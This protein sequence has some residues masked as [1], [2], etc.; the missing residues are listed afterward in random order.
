MKKTLS[1]LICCLFFALPLFISQPTYA[2]VIGTLESSNVILDFD[3][4]KIET[5]KVLDTTYVPVF[6]LKE[7]GCNVAFDATT[8]DVNL[9]LSATNSSPSDAASASLVGKQYELYEKNIWI[10]GFKTHGITTE[11]RVLIPIGALRQLYQININGTQYQ[12][13]VKEPLGIAAS[14][15]QITN[16]LNEKATVNVTDLYWDNGWVKEVSTYALAPLEVRS[17]TLTKPDLYYVSTLIT[18]V[19]TPSFTLINENMFGQQNDK[20][21]SR[22]FRLQN[23][24]PV[25]DLGDPLDI[26]TLIWAEDTVNS[27]NLPSSTP[28]LVWTNI[29]TQKTFIF[30]GSNHNW[31]LIKHFISSTGKDRTPT[32]KGEFKLTA[33]VP[34]FGVEKG[35][36][37]KNAFGFI[38]TT[39]L[40]HSILFDKTGSYLLEGKG[41][42]GNKASDGCIRFSEPNSKWFY[43]NMISGTK[44]WIN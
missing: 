43:D 44:V 17:R 18:K 40:Y 30:E 11:G 2:A 36:R 23:A 38:G 21:F 31:K 16:Q 8:G 13:T 22:H 26:S 28:Y 27:K 6:R 15:S 34:Y 19:Q 29:D 24:T 32:P 42:L 37:C 39:Y 33:K 41:V 4:Y 1:V 7:M 12:M 3:G 5:Y 20:L 9:S 10:D 14:S 35:Y 25:T